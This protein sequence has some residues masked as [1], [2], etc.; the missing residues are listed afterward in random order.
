MIDLSKISGDELQAEL[1]RRRS[2]PP[3]LPIPLSNPDFTKLRDMIVAEATTTQEKNGEDDDFS[4]YV[5]EAAMEA[6]YGPDAYW[7][8]V[9]SLEA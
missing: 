7:D 3:A 8:W 5:Y 1:D 6:V 9:N 4:H 2:V